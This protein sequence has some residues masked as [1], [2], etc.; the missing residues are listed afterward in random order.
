MHE[1]RVFF[2]VE[3]SV[4]YE[5]YIQ[6]ELDRINKNKALEELSIPGDFNYKKI[7][8][9]SNESKERLL[10]VLPET[11]GQASRVA[12]IRPTDITI[13]GAYIRALGVSRET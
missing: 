13:L 3:T 7:E 12:G 1:K 9:I 6:N 2:E 5:G 8:G 4:K 11:L 10:R